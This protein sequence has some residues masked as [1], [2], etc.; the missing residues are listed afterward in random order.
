M[1][2]FD[3]FVGREKELAQ[4]DQ[5]AGQWN[6]PQLVV[7]DGVG[8]IGKTFLLRKVMDRYKERPNFAVVYYDLSEQPPGILREAAQIA[9][10]LGWENFPEFR[11]VINDLAS[12]E[13]DVADIRLPQLEQDALGAFADEMNLFLEHTRVI[14]LVDTL[15]AVVPGVTREQYVYQY[16][17]LFS[18]MLGI[19][20]GRQA[21]ALVPKFKKEFGSDNVAYIKLERFNQ[22]ESREFFDEVDKEGL[23]APELRDKLYY[24]TDGRPILMTLA[25]EWLSRDVPLPEIV[26][27]SLSDLQNLPEK[28]LHTLR[29]SFEFQLVEPVR[30]LQTPLYRAILYMAHISRRSDAPILSKLLEMSPGAAEALVGQLAALSFVRHNPLTQS[31]MLH[32]EMKRL[33]NQ[34][35]WPYVDPLGEVRYKLTRQVISGYYE[36]RIQALNVQIKAQLEEES[37]SVRP[38]EISAV[39]WE[40]WRL[41]AECLYYYLQLGEEEGLAYFND[42]FEDAQRNNHLMRMQFLLSEME[43]TGHAD[44]RDTLELRYAWTLHLNGEIVQAREICRTLLEKP[45]LSR[46]NRIHVHNTLGWIAMATDPEGARLHYEAALN[47]SEAGNIAEEISIAHNNLGQLYHSLGHLEQ[48]VEHYQ[49]AIQAGQRAGNMAQVASSSNNLAY[50]YRLLG[51]LS[52]ADVLCRVALAQ[53]KR[54]GQ[55]RGLAFSYLTKGEIDRDRGD[56][57]SAEYHSKLALRIFDK[58]DEVRGQIMCYRLLANIRRHLKQYKE[59]EAY[60]KRA[61]VLAEQVNDEPLLASVLDVYGREQRDCAVDLQAENGADHPSEVAVLFQSAERYLERSIELAE[62]YGNQWLNVRNRFELALTYHL[63]ASHT[64]AYVLELLNQLWEGARRLEY[65]LLLGY[66]DEARGEIAERRADYENAARYYGLAAQWVAHQRGRE[67]ERFFDR[68]GERL[69][70]TKLPPA[71]A[72]VLSRGILDVIGGEDISPATNSLCMLCEQVLMFC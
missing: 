9:E 57:E 5:W 49:S 43:I 70:N 10:S 33:I 62:R 71:A 7:V 12:G 26:M 67:V 52:E 32:D 2:K 27:Q 34:H 3:I 47:L 11:G 16:G 55:E 17:E 14:R 37:V 30:R 61:I 23:I 63:S 65:K 56:L 60:L 44:I 28:D 46:E 36:P 66:I 15:D 41:E 38:T 31:C 8:G 35:A 53:R 29:E 21:V 24:L 4:I 72:C 13:Y 69:L 39:E 6:T 20:A 50:V 64:D 54:L 22:V 45:S 19:S 18:N 40:L 42:R 58:V 51:N 48:A 59:A 1:A 25:V 68:L